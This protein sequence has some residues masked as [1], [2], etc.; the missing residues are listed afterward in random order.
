MCLASLAA[1]GQPGSWT[2]A[3]CSRVRPLT[4]RSMAAKSSYEF[5]PRDSTLDHHLALL[6]TTVRSLGWGGAS[7]TTEA[8]AHPQPAGGLGTPGQPAS[9]GRTSWT[10]GAHP[11]LSRVKLRFLS[12]RMGAPGTACI[13]FPWLPLLDQH[14]PPAGPPGTRLWGQG[15]TGV[16]VP[17][18]NH[19][20]EFKEPGRKCLGKVAAPAWRPPARSPSGR[21]AEVCGSRAAGAYRPPRCG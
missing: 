9:Q 3:I 8:R 5:L 20:S 19:T 10:Q 15:A 13:L 17:G 12:Q 16:R 11:G 7:D 4:P 14:R 18:L 21:R 6:P 1:G 2:F